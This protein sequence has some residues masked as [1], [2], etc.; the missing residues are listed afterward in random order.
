M[1]A[2]FITGTGTDIGK[3]WLCAALLSDWRA[4]GLATQAIKP[5][6]SGVNPAELEAGDAGA[7]LQAQGQAVNAATVAA[8]APWCFAAPLSPDMAAALE[9]RTIAFDE[10]VA[11]SCRAASTD[12]YT[13]IEGIGGVMVPIDDTHTVLDWI[14]AVAAPTVLV[15]GSYLGSMSHTL[16]ALKALSSAGAAVAAIVVNESQGSSVDLDATVESLRRHA[17][18]VPVF[19]VH[20]TSPTAD[21]AALA[22]LLGDRLYS[23]TSLSPSRS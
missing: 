22:R 23:A 17:G 14:I 9:G 11:F 15:A 6:M 13:L 2:Y 18:N 20:R 7:L 12:F 5:V 10:L 16:T 19:A 21:L 8:I 4:Q 3:T 1:A